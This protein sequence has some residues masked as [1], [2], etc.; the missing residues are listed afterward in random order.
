MYFY[1]V[2]GAVFTSRLKS[3]IAKS[4]A[5][6]SIEVQEAVLSSIKAVFLLPPEQQAPVLAAYSSSVKDVFV[7]G[8]PATILASIAAL[9]IIRKKIQPTTA[10]PI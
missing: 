9:F 10:V 8:I 7:I 2:A 4:Q 6:L 1:S 5:Q 3:Q